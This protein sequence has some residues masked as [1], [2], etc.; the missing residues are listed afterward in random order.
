MYVYTYVYTTSVKGGGQLEV[1]TV[2]TDPPFPADRKKNQI[3]K[4]V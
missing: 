2:W 3:W 4:P 1:Q